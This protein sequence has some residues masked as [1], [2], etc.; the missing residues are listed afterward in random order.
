MHI[1]DLLLAY[2]LLALI[3]LMTS[4]LSYGVAL[5]VRSEDALAPLMNTVAQ[6]VLLLSG[7]LLPLTFAPGWLQ[8]HRRLEPVLVGGRRH[9]GAVRRRPGQRPGLAGAAHHGGARRCWPWSGRPGS[10]PAASADSG[11]SVAWR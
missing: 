6:P 3:A 11:R 10:S 7:I 2:L 8:R 5:R 9:P 1:G 4:A